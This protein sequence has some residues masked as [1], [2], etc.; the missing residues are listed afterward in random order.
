VLK[1][2]IQF[3]PSPSEISTVAVLN[4]ENPQDKYF[5]VYDIRRSSTI[6]KIQKHSMEDEA[7]CVEESG[8]FLIYTE[9]D[10]LIFKLI[11]LPSS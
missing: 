9:A 11:R 7:F 10:E 3:P 4:C 5:L 6:R 8:R 1:S 2:E